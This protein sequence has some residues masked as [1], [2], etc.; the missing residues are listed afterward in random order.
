MSEMF[1]G[2]VPNLSKGMV[3]GAVA[4]SVISVTISEISV[5]GGDWWR[6]VREFLIERIMFTGG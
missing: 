3:C 5:L 1:V 2:D 4:E 6:L